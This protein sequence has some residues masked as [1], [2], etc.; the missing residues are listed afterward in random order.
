MDEKDMRRGYHRRR[1]FPIVAV[2]LLV[3]GVLWLMTDLKVIT[4]DIPWIPI[5]VIIFAIGMIANRYRR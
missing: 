1:G 5:V 2:I 3:V 4:V